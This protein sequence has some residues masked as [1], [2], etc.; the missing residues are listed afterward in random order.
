LLEIKQSQQKKQKQKQKQNK[1]KPG[2]V[3]RAFYPS[4]W[5]AEASGFLSLRLAWSTK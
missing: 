1:N 4:T 2:L 5:E 3:A